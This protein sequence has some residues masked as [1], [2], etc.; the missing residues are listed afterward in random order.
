MERFLQVIAY[1]DTHVAVWLVDGQLRKLSKA[2]TQTIERH[3][4]LLSPTV[5]PELEYTYEIGCI[6]KLSAI[7]L[8]RLQGRPEHWN[9]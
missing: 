9:L 7:V 2:V 5:L 1:L 4:L 6:S 8:G 3:S